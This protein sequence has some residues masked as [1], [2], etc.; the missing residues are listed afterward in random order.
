M[1]SNT[2]LIALI[3]AA[4]AGFATVGYPRKGLAAT[5]EAVPP[6]SV[7]PAVSADQPLA[8]PSPAGEA[9]DTVELRLGAGSPGA[10]DSELLVAAVRIQLAD[11]GV[12]LEISQSK[13]PPDR[14]AASSSRAVF[15]VTTSKLGV[16]ELFL[17]EPRS[18]Q[19]R[20]R[21]LGSYQT[22]I[23]AAEEISLVMRS[24]VVA[25]LS[26]ES[27]Q[28]QAVKTEP[29]RVSSTPKEPAP[30][31]ARRK[32][33]ASEA[34]Q[35]ERDSQNGFPGEWSFSAGYIGSRVSPEAVQ[36]GL[37]ISLSQ[38]LGSV[39]FGVGYQLVET[40][41]YVEPDVEVEL[42]YLP[43]DLYVSYLVRRGGLELGAELGL[44]LTRITRQTNSRAVEVEP[45]PE[46][47]H[48]TFGPIGRVRAEWLS[49][50]NV[51]VYALLGASAPLNDVR[52]AIAA[53][54]GTSEILEPSRLQAHWSGGMVARWF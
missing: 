36:D 22:P 27:V 37:R 5:G 1:L 15:W 28:M 49:E 42:R 48:W 51:G 18:Q 33:S 29:I 41:N 13:H 31:P 10:L 11:L 39:R 14:D 44:G 7:A 54:E 40:S 3:G 46:Q 16:V 30:A 2:D 24:A 20:V 43:F 8:V 26:G 47:A 6:E 9:L 50:M 32:P 25:L 53:R 19:L 45:T 21:S 52:Y 12:A 38:T 4:L 23:V 35:P 17:R 34:K